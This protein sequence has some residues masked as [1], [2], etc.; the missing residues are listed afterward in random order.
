MFRKSLAS[1]LVVLA[2]LATASASLTEVRRDFL[3][4]T[5]TFSATNVMTAPTA[6]GSYFITVYLDQPVGGTVAATIAWIDEN[7]SPQQYQVFSGTGVFAVR[8]QAGTTLTVQTAGSVSGTYNLFVD[9]VG[10][11]N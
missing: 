5:A 2:L 7:G 6:D 10:F 4:Q 1:F 11:W 8:L 3:N 9:G